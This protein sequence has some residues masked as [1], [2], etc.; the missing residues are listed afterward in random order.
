MPTVNA[1]VDA[2]IA[3]SAP[4]AQPI[5][6]YLREVAHEAAPEVVEAMKWSR[7]F[8]MYRGV[9][10]GNLSAFKEHCSFGLWGK[11]IAEILRADGVA[12]SEG[13]GTFGRITAVKDLPP[14]KKLVGYVKQAVKM[15][16]EGT[17]T[18]SMAP[19]ARVA[20]VAVAVPETLAVALK[21]NKAAAKHFEAMSPSCRREYSEWIA[22]AKREETRDKRVAT[23][24]EWIAEGKSRNWKYEKC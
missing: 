1:A 7:P 20:K 23:A 5:L 3:K 8:F 12:S 16:A 13:M 10:L 18:Q 6:T 17:R 21:K 24:L 4:F 14:R 15:I 9:I 22:D 2:Y 19:R 11:E